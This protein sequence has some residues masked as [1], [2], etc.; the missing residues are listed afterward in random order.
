MK[1]NQ[2]VPT[3][4]DGYLNES[5]S[6]M[7]KRGYGSR[8][9]VIV[10]AKGNVRDQV[11]PFV[12][13]N[14]KVSGKV[15]RKFI[16]GLN[17]QGSKPAA[18]N[19]WIKRNSKYFVAESKNGTTFYTLSKIGKRLV[20]RMRPILEQKGDHDFIDKKK[21]YDRPGITSSAN[22]DDM[23]DEACDEALVAEADTAGAEIK[24]GAIEKYLAGKKKRMH[25]KSEWANLLETKDEEEEDE[26]TVEEMAEPDEDAEK[27][28][29][30][31]DAR[32]GRIEKLLEEIKAKRD[33]EKLNEEDEEDED[34]L[35]FDDIDLGDDDEEEGEEGDAAEGE[36]GD[37]DGEVENIEIAE[38][39]LTVDDADAAIAELEE[40]GITAEMVTDEG[41]AE[42]DDEFD[43]EAEEEGEEGGDEDLFGDAEEGEESEEAEDTDLDLGLEEADD[44]DEEVDDSGFDLGGDEEDT[45]ELEDEEEVEDIDLGD[46]A[47]EGEDEVED[48]G[49]KIRVSAEHAEELVKYLEEKG[50]DVEEMFGGELDIEGGDEDEE[51]EEGEE[52][53]EP[54]QDVE[55]AEDVDSEEDAG[56]E[57][58]E[59]LEL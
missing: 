6:F 57:E 43:L 7:L 4:L 41:E 26:K 21:G 15:L 53:E 12:A 54:A 8:K 27:L 39:I 2:Y 31:S 5:K 29:E 42:E 3:T 32:K 47:E 28:E 50:V 17:E 58:D 30:E 51:G 1:N 13:E 11:L 23:T 33:T 45:V 40:R 10:G 18:V 14:R 22:E 49:Q 55:D 16:T 36:E 59:E 38:F 20:N 9:P 46:D 44:T 56:G 48:E 37:D 19:M 52:G 34:E 25:K 24:T 35:T